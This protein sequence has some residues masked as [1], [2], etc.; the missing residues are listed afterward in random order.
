MPSR[1]PTDPLLALWQMPMRISA[2]YCELWFSMLP[3]HHLSG[4]ER[5]DKAHAQLV[6]PEPLKTIEDRDLFA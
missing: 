6:V 3:S 1:P 2:Q 5:E 4:E